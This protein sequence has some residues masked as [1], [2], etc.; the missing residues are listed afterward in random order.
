[1]KKTLIYICFPIVLIA[2]L[3]SGCLEEGNR[4]PTTP[5]SPPPLASS[6]ASPEAEP[7][8]EPDP[9]PEAEPTPEPDPAPEAEPTPET[10]P[11]PEAEPTPETDPAP[12]AEPTPEPDP[13]PEA[14][15]TPEPD[16]AP[17]AEPTPEPDPAPEAEPT[18][19]PD[20]TPEA[21][22][23]PEP[24]PVPEAEPTPETDPAPEA[25][26]TPEPDPAPE[27]KPTQEPDQP[28]EA[29]SD[30]GEP[31]WVYH[32]TIPILMYHEVNDLLANSLYLSVK[33][34]TDHL[35]YFEQAG[36][37][38]ISMQQ[39][40]D[41]W[42]NEAPLPEKPIVLT[43]DDGYR[44]MYTTVYPLLKERGW[45]G[46][47]F[48]ITDSRW[49]KNSLLEHMIAEMAANGM[50]IGSHTASH[51]ELNALTGNELC[52]ELLNSRDILA[53]I[54]GREITMLCYPAGR[55]NNETKTAASEAGYL[56]AVTTKYGFATK[57]QGMFELK[58][59]RISQGNGAAWLK[60]TLA[61]L[62]Y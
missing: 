9:A 1:M 33:D 22:P 30:G 10:D 20:P 5:S 48:C 37:T 32:E 46:T 35:E 24:D 38:P 45:S 3:L 47:F 54:T 28:A 21:E 39:L 34:F 8:P 52:R 53:S 51:R 4:V 43:F 26:P 36:I 15:P 7:T 17:E 6:P 19:E 58:R 44:S 12:E 2:I 56:C 25:E 41:H 40:Y 62:G 23:T 49:S 29:P 31:G 13:A 60:S 11:A 50:E 57:S 42:F 61:P 27:A 16:P 18:P 55:Y 14:E 59:I